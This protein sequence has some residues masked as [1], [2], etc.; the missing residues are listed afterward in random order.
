VKSEDL[1]A[2][3]TALMERCRDLHED[4]NLQAVKDWK[5]ATGGHAVGSLPI[6][7]P[8]EILHAAGILPVGL[9]GGGDRVDVI[10]GDAYFQSYICRLPRSMVELGLSDRMSALDGVLFPAICDVIRNLSGIW[11]M[12]FPDQ[13]VRFVD[14]PQNFD[15]EIG[16]TFYRGELQRLADDM[17]TLAGTEVT[18]AALNEAIELYDLNRDLIRR[19]HHAR[20]DTP[21]KVSTYELYLLQRAGHLLPVT[22]H[23]EMLGEYLDLATSRSAGPIDNARIL[24]VGAFCEQPPLPLIRSLELA[25]C[26]IVEDD[27]LMGNRLLGEVGT[28]DDPLGRLTKAYFSPQRPCSSVYDENGERMTNL[29]ERVRR[30]RADGVLFASPS[31]CDPALLDRPIYQKALEDA[32]IPFTMLKYAENTRQLSAIREQ[33]GTFA[34]SIRLWGDAP[35]SPAA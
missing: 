5:A 31:F 3:I 22:E 23:N 7:V 2:R 6:Y 9:I 8:D 15:P 24:I 21:E 27:M 14:F 1:E 18:P 17:A 34:E 13:F 11:T 19:L 20:Q 28:G 29:I 12:L 35:A 32:H 25:G 4:I 10:R 30:L 26:F 16:G 33:V